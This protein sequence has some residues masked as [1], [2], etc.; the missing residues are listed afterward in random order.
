MISMLTMFKRILLAGM[1]LA[2]A[3]YSQQENTIF[4]TLFTNVALPQI[5]QLTPEMSRGQAG[6]QAIVIFVNAPAHVCTD[7]HSS[8]YLEGSYDNTTWT[9]FGTNIP[10]LYNS[11]NPV[12]VAGQ[13]AFPYIR[14]N[15]F[16]FDIINCRAT[17]YYS[18]VTYQS[19]SISVIGST[20]SQHGPPILMGGTNGFANAQP[21]VSC[22]GSETFTL[23]APGI[24]KLV[25]SET[26]NPTYQATNRVYLCSVALNGPVAGTVE[27]SYGDAHDTCNATTA[28]SP[29][30]NIG[31]GVN[32][33]IWGSGLGWVTQTF[34]GKALCATLAGVGSSA[35]VTINYSTFT[36]F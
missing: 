17:A 29:K 5:G 20:S 22:L 35:Q 25:N 10:A 33:T 9:T 21:I 27:L 36:F 26:Q 3:A 2:V 7:P 24:T 31:P 28:I 15:L 12:L 18:G 30:F 19:P 23:A 13:G 32:N 11:A 1:L 16:A 4:G 6:H 34:P 14:L 8:A